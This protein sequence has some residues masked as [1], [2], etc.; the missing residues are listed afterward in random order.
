MSRFQDLL[1]RID[2]ALA[3]AS[4]TGGDALKIAD[5]ARRRGE[6]ERALTAAEEAWLEL[7]EEAGGREARRRRHF[8]VGIRPFQGVAAPFS[9]RGQLSIYSIS[10]R[11]GFLDEL[12]VPHA[13]PALQAFS[14]IRKIITTSSDIVKKMLPRTAAIS[15]PSRP[16]EIL[17]KRL[18]LLEIP[19]PRDCGK[20]RLDS[21]RRA[22]SFVFA[23]VRRPRALDLSEF[24]CHAHAVRSARPWRPRGPEPNLPGAR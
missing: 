24:D 22:R 5:L 8:H 15:A 13:R 3:E 23:F 21:R 2:E 14:V 7:S 16:I 1:R 10:G 11:G 4:A 19:T 20:M 9:I 18:H 12:V 6:L 17:T